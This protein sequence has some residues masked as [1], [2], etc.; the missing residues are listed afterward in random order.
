MFSRLTL[1]W[2]RFGLARRV[3]THGWTGVYVGDYRTAPSWTYTLG[4]DETLDQPEIIIFDIPRDSANALLWEVYRQLKDGRL[5]LE[6]SALWSA[7]EEHPPMWRKVDPSQIAGAVG[8]LTMAARRRFDRTGK[9]FGLEAFQLVL[10]DPEGRFPWEDDYDEHLRRRQPALYLPENDPDATDMPAEMREARRLMA[11]RG[12]TS[13]PVKGPEFNWAYTIGLHETFGAPDLITFALDAEP[14]ASMLV[15]VRSYLR[16]GVV[17]P[18]DGRRWDGLG[19]EVCFR[20]VH[21]TQYLGFNWF[22][23]AKEIREERTGRREAFPA[24]QLFVPDDDGRY[25]WEDGCDKLFADA[26]PQLFLPLD[27]EPTTRRLLAAANA[28]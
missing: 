3:S 17:T 23:L 12:W 14:M 5:R 25:P 16:D 26:Q 8:W 20:A 18:S 15:D 11:E 4:F 7:G 19:F 27:V 10:P 6:D 22:Y 13:V 21:E 28:V 1:A 2:V 24:Y 9:T